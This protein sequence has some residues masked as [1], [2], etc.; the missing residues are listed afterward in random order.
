MGDFFLVLLIILM[1]LYAFYDE[2]FMKRN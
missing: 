1:T 2:L